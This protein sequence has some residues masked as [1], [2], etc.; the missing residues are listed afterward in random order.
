[1]APRTALCLAFVFTSALL[2]AQAPSD[3]LLAKA[4]Q[5][6]NDEN[7]VDQAISAFHNT[8]DP[9]TL[10]K[11]RDLFQ[12]ITVRPLRRNF[13]A[14]MFG[15]LGQKDDL[16]FDALAKYAQE[17]V[18]SDAPLWYLYDPEGNAI[19]SEPTLAFTNWC[20]RHQLKLEVCLI[21]VAEEGVDVAVLAGIKDRRA[22][23][24]FRQ[25]LTSEDLGVVSASTLGLALLNEWDSIPLIATAIRRFRPI[26]QRLIASRLA[27]YNDPGAW[28]L[29][30]E[31]IKD[32][33]WRQEVDN[34]IRKRLAQ[35]SKQ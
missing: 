31:F 25:G 1:M 34:S 19:R 4:P 29:L 8:K 22:I 14:F 28:L 23:P 13:A 17:S 33:K 30:D 24:I 6:P 11:L 15:T 10:S 7:V 26:Q 12:A 3:E 35:P 2:Q 5:N 27:Q 32:P 18:T 21:T 16:Y 20:E 9:A